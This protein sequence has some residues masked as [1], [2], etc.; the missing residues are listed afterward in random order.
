MSIDITDIQQLAQAIKDA[1]TPPPA[2]NA[3]SIKLPEFWTEDPELWFAR[4]EAQ[5]ATRDIRSDDTKFHYVVAALDNTTAAEVKAV[6]LKPPTT[7][8]YKALRRALMDAFAKSQAQKDAELLAISGLGDRRPTALLRKIQSLNSDSDTLLRA[9]FL[10][11][12]PQDVR[13][14]LAAMDAM[15]IDALAKAAD[16]IIESK[17]LASHGVN[18]VQEVSVVRDRGAPKPRQTSYLSSSSPSNICYFH[19]KF[20]SKARTCRPGC[21]FSDL[22]ASSA[23]STKSSGQ[24]LRSGNDNA[25]RWRSQ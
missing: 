10:A 9:F 22:C 25:G 23:P 15:N 20:G 1:G 24:S 6:L 3:A 4:V 17:S 7:D 11:Q 21:L 2:V 12:L 19:S 13:A 14:V 18:E 16:R 8:R 5:F